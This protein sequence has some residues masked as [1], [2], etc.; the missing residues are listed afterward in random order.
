MISILG[1]ILNTQL[2]IFAQWGNYD[3]YGMQQKRY[4]SAISEFNK[5]DVRGISQ[6]S[7]SR[8]F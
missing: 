6:K 7:N 4:M 1:T 2:E 5:W 8:E 3:I